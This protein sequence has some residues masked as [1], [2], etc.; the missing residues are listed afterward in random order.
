[1]NDDDL[2]LSIAQKH[3]GIQPLLESFFSFLSRRTDFFHVMQEGDKMGFPPGVAEKMVLSTFRKFQSPKQPRE[4]TSV[5][6]NTASTAASTTPSMAAPRAPSMAAPA[7]TSTPTTAEPTTA[8]STATSAAAAA[9]TATAFSTYNGGVTE[10]YR[11][12]QT[13]TDV[14]LEIEVPAGTKANQLVVTFSSARLKVGL[15]GAPLLIDGELDDKIRVEDCFWNLED[16]RFLHVNME[17][18]RETWWKSVIKGDAE[19]DTT[20]VDSTRNVQ[21][22][23]P[24]TQG[25]IRKIMFD[26]AQKAAGLPTSDELKNQE[27]LRKAWDAEGSPFKG[28]PFDPSILNMQQGNDNPAAPFM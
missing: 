17:K 22:Y 26:Q 16:G 23:D 12:Q 1:M 6:N 13:L 25:A 7:A 27:M 8:A 24:E 18:Q 10:R 19:I 3:G 20:K 5:T 2:Y 28:Q 4:T 15:K 21:D 11:W 14:V 9:P